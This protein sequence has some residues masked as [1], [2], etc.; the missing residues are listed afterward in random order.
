MLAI[1]ICGAGAASAFALAAS[2]SS[3]HEPLGPGGAF[4]GITAGI[5]AKDVGVVPCF[6]CS[7]VSCLGNLFQAFRIAS[8]T[9]FSGA[10]SA[11]LDLDRP[12]VVLGGIFTGGGAGF[13][14]TWVIGGAGAC[15]IGGVFC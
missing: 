13:C 9:A 4:I 10:G 1:G 12:R 6:G 7:G 3:N 14:T 8:V 11:F 2:C 5:V 15:F